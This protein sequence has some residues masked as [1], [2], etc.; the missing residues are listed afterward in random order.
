M[1]LLYIPTR[2]SSFKTEIKM[3]ELLQKRRDPRYLG[4]TFVK[5]QHSLGGVVQLYKV[6]SGLKPHSPAGSENKLSFKNVISEL[7]F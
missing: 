4:F 2:V 5:T 6:D 1:D 3:E 7:Y